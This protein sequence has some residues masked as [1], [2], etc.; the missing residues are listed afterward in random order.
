MITCIY[1][2]NYIYIYTHNNFLKMSGCDDVWKCKC[3][4]ASKHSHKARWA[5]ISTYKRNYSSKYKKANWNKE[6]LNTESSLVKKLKIINAR[7]ND[8]QEQY[9]P[10]KKVKFDEISNQIVVEI[11]EPKQYKQKK[12]KQSKKNTKGDK[13]MIIE[14]DLIELRE[15]FGYII[16]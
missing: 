11:E 14:K 12:A 2:Y 15:L 1:I 5:F 9:V 6:D 16:K 4:C 10:I 7:P 8:N 13:K 3:G